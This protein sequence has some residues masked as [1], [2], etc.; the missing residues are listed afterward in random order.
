[1]LL[2]NPCESTTSA[3]FL[4]AGK[5]RDIRD[6]QISQLMTNSSC[7][8]KDFPRCV[9]IFFK[10]PAVLFLTLA[11][12]MDNGLVSGIATFGPKQYESM[13]TLTASNAAFIFGKVHLFA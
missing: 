9:L 2:E 6:H 1:M 5:P 7:S 12:A 3:S 10:N 11:G 8:I 13:F 4:I